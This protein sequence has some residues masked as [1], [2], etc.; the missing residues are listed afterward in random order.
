MSTFDCGI[1]ERIYQG[2]RSRVY[3]ACR[4]SDR[5]PV[6]IKVPTLDR[7]RAERV[8]GLQGELA[9]LRRLAG[10]AAV[11]RP[12]DIARSGEDVGLI[13]HDHG[14]RS[15]HSLGLAGLIGIPSY[16][17]MAL[18]LAEALHDIHERGVIHNDI[19]P[20]HVLLNGETQ[21]LQIIG[22]S[23]SLVIERSG[24][25]VRLDYVIR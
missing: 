7:P 23:R 4:N 20:D 13:L 16:L 24:R 11:A 9:V 17:D 18:Q 5:A 1:S 21:Q 15:L 12:Y 10:V 8:R 14:A 2:P 22:F 19:N 25:R 3:R 6:I